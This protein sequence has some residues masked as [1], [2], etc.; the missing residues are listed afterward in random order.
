MV[1]STHSASSSVGPEQT[2]GEVL[3]LEVEEVLGSLGS[4]GSLA[5][6]DPLEPLELLDPLALATLSVVIAGAR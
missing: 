1:G 2:L 3:E 4:L 6:L 5:S